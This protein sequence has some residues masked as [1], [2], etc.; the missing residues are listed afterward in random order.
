VFRLEG[1]AYRPQEQPALGDQAAKPKP[2]P[3]SAPAR[4]IAS[5]KRLAVAGGGSEEWEEF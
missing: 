1:G 4:A 3:R 5:S 2:A